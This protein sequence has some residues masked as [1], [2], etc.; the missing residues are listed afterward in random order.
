MFLLVK[1]FPDSIG[2]GTKT[3]NNSDA[4]K[5]DGNRYLITIQ[6]SPEEP[7]V[8]MYYEASDFGIQAETRKVNTAA[9]KGSS[10]G[11]GSRCGFRRHRQTQTSTN[12]TNLRRKAQW[13]LQLAPGSLAVGNLCRGDEGD[14][15]VY[16]DGCAVG[17]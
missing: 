13:H 9:G 16:L 15:L 11:E 2:S 10:A 12:C 3:S 7:D 8:S 6:R 5:Y 1:H 14:C 17:S 4:L